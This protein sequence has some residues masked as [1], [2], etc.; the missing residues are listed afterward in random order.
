VTWEPDGHESAY[1]PAWPREHRATPAERDRRRHRPIPWDATLAKGDMALFDNER[2]P[3]GRAAFDATS[4][5]RHIRSCYVDRESVHG[6]L[7][8]IGKR[9]GRTDTELRLAGSFGP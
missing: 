3:H 6:Q 7:R 9:L 1:D 4:G 8:L 5:A 2:V